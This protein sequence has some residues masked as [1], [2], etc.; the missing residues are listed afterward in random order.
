MTINFNGLTKIFSESE[1]TQL[2][3]N[4]LEQGKN[5]QL[6]YGM[7]GSS[8]V[9]MAASLLE[10][11]Y[12][13]ILVTANGEEAK[14]VYSD[15]EVLLPGLNVG[16]FPAREIM[17]Y[18]VYAHSNELQNQR[19]A[20][21][22]ELVSEQ[23]QCVVAPIS[24]LLVSLVPK[25]VF[26][27]AIKT[28][29]QHDRLELDELVNWLVDQG[30][31]RVDKVENVAQ[32]CVRGGIVD[33]YPVAEQPVRVEFFGEEID[34]VRYIDVSTQ[35]SETH[36][37]R[38]VLGPAKELVLTEEARLRGKDAIEAE[39]KNNRKKFVASKN[40]KAL[41]RLSEK[42]G[43]AMDKL[44]RQL[45]AVGLEQFHSFFYPESETI[46]DYFGSPVVIWDE[47]ARIEEESNRLAKERADTYSQLLMDGALLPSQ[48]NNYL[49][50]E[51]LAQRK[52]QGTMF[53]S[54]L[55]KRL[56]FELQAEQ[57]VNFDIR[58]AQTFLGKM[59]MLISEISRWINKRNRIV[60]ATADGER[61]ER[62]KSYLWDAGI[63]AVISE[64]VPDKIRYGSVIITWPGLQQ[65]FQSLKEKLIVLTDSELYGHRRPT[66]KVFRKGKKLDIFRDLKVGGY[67]VHANHGLGRYLGIEQ[68]EVGG[69]YKDYLHIQYAGEDKLYLPTEQVSL[70]QPY[71]GAEG[72]VPKLN[73]LG[74]NEWSRVKKRVKQSVEELAKDLLALYAARETVKGFGFP[75]DSEW[76]KEFEAQFPYR[77]TEDQLR[78]IE[79]VKADMEL[80]KSMDRLLVG[81]VGYGKTEVAMRAIFKAC[82][83]GKQTAILVPTTVLAQQHLLTFTERFANFPVRIAVLS[84]FI[85]KA[86]QKAALNGIKDGSIDIV[87]GTHRL[88]SKDIKFKDL[89]LLVIDEEQRFGVKHK[90]KLKEL[91]H[92]VDVLTLSATPIPRTLHMSLV[93]VRDMSVIET[94]PE[95]RYPVQT[96][97][98]E[99]SQELVQDAIY[100]ELNRGGQ[101]FYVYNRVQGITKKAAQIQK[102]IPEAI[103]GVGHGQMPEK[104]LEQVML[105]FIEGKSN[106][107]VCTTIVENGLD[108]QNA[109]TLIVDEADRM[110][111]S[112]LYQI[113]GRVGRT[114]RMA[115]AYLTYRKDKVLSQEAEKRLAAIREFTELGSG[116]KIAMRDLEIRG[117]GNILGSEQHGHMLSVGFDL[118]CRLLEDA[119]RRLKGEQLDVEEEPP[120]MELAVDAYL[121]D[122][123]ISDP[124]EK[125]DCY[126]RL[127]NA[128]EDKTID[129]IAQNLEDRFGKRPKEVDN[130]L[131][132]AR[133][134]VLG[135]SLG[136][137]RIRQVNAEL[138]EIRFKDGVEIGGEKLMQI[139]QEF[140][141]RLGISV[142]QGLLLQ[143][144]IKRLDQRNMLELLENV[145]YKAKALV[146][147]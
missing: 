25:Q 2:L 105:D 134:K 62:L 132:L 64:I 42:I 69:V 79:E 59:D 133:L 49:E 33:I 72:H 21:M 117:A 145:L 61:A 107:L 101:V 34:S 39:F 48:N 31:E 5:I 96:Y 81:D 51:Q 32:F 65:G 111:L 83:A 106:V 108:I 130:L 46:I 125:I 4:G 89:G 126:R 77:E 16:Y 18:E 98:V 131:A 35:R 143:V 102:L 104:E 135:T 60:L 119:V 23:L 67:L 110:G 140:G 141:R 142:V 44:D 55:P 26:Q 13:L 85:T 90:E 136:V 12:K 146:V 94:P 11:G 113:R 3:L 109:N 82:E 20:I 87:I 7:G 95:E 120:S 47:M 10:K 19:L 103:L 91:R 100:R 147:D 112:Q 129:N 114:N 86:N 24:S 57:V 40:K 41:D 71:V 27:Q 63:E 14:K 123:Y 76:Q 38:V 28:I 74:G 37:E 68:L 88:L 43:N 84:R 73:K 127:T 56:P 116:F 70:I 17:P 66:K 144:K 137:S 15:L 29:E 54:L 58:S 124:V 30:Y 45:W 92:Q 139:A 138:V 75:P 99:H 115:Y 36:V 53:I 8:K 6:G 121:S 52:C 122:N 80:Q 22:K 97:V 50:L 93:G 1:P 78:A 118:Y 128:V 9:L